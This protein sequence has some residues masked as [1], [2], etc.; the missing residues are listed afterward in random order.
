MGAVPR[1]ENGWAFAG[2]GGS[3]PS[4][5][6]RS[7]VVELVRR[8]TVNR[9]GQVRVLPPELASRPRGRTGNDA[10]LSTRKLRV[11]VPPGVFIWLWGRRPLRRF[12]EPEIAGSTPAGQTCAVEERLSSRAS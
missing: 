1:L 3:T 7:G 11:R 10:G 8:A 6:A 9:E 2:L 4:P 5:S 12:R